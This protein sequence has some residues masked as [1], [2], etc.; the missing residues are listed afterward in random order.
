MNTVLESGLEVQFFEATINLA[1]MGVL[2]ILDNQ[3]IIWIFLT[4]LVLFESNF[5]Q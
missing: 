5:L 4:S 3:Y 1:P 2:I